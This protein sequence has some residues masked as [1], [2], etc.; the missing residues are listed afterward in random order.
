MLQN[1]EREGSEA[2]GKGERGTREVKGEGGGRARTP[3]LE[4][5]DERET[6]K[7]G[8][9]RL[10][11]RLSSAPSSGKSSRWTVKVDPG[12]TEKHPSTEMVLPRDITRS[13]TSNS[14]ACY[15]LEPT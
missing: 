14:S 11:T 15:A 1:E 10:T 12:A 6:E 2:W 8:K 4:E 7:A 3:D 13:P 9:G 5:R